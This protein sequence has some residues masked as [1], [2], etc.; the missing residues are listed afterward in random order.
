MV[1][2]ECEETAT[3]T[4]IHMRVGECRDELAPGWLR[5]RILVNLAITALPVWLAQFCL[6]DLPRRV[7]RDNIDALD[8]RW[9]LEAGQTLTTMC[10]ELFL[11]GVIALGSDNEGQWRL[12]PALVGYAD[13]SDVG[14]AVVRH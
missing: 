11:A 6:Q 4:E 7:P 12:T 2:G 5:Y 9:A 3:Q 14:N 1:T 13:D 8:S 10:D